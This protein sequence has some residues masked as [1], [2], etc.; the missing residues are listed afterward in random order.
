[1]L[2]A[3]LGAA[4]RQS[5]IQIPATWGQGRATYGGLVGA[6]LLARMLGEIGADRVLRSA[7][8]SFVGP[9]AAGDAALSVEVLRRGKSAVQA[10]AR[11]I[12]AGQVQAVLLAS[13]GQPRDSHIVVEPIHH[14]PTFAPASTLPAM[15]YV[16]GVMP[17]FFQHM[18][19]R[20]AKGSMPFS[21][22]A[23]DFAGW[24][25]F[26]NPIDQFGVVHLLALIDCWPP[27]VLPMYRSPAPASSLAWTVEFVHIPSQM[28]AEDFWQYRVQ[29]DVARQGYAHTE[30]HI[31]AANGD[32]IAIS[33]QTV[34]VFA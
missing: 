7:T 22:A 12:Q 27:A 32:L 3:V 4:F 5:E 29:T 11:L 19:L 23:P 13:F 31:W 26:N 24:M 30:A 9:V 8:V 6:L 21:A 28:H 16:D 17:E 1:M 33:R 15:P 2:D 18:D 20:W 10:Q 34:A 14:A 25:R